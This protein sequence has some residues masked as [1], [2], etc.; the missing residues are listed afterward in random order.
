MKFVKVNEDTLRCLITEEEM[1]GFGIEIEDLLSDREKVQDFLQMVLA[2]AEEET[3]FRINGAAISVE[4]TLLP[5]RGVSLTISTGNYPENI[6]DKLRRFHDA[7]KDYAKIQEGFLQQQPPTEETA[8]HLLIYTA[9][10]LMELADFCRLLP[11][12]N[13]ES[14]LY[15]V[16]SRSCYYLILEKE[17]TGDEMRQLGALGLEF[18]IGML[19]EDAVK[20]Y[21]VEHGTC[22]IKQGAL[23]LLNGL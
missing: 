14:S 13:V 9:P 8:G 22:V 20:C 5:G 6:A 2:D 3:G 21:V 15:K 23:E 10:S 12:E 11:V 16:D 1:A 18:E 19:L 17:F 7:L 4:A